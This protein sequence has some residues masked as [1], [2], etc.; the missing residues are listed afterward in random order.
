MSWQFITEFSFERLKQRSFPRSSLIMDDYKVGNRNGTT[1][2]LHFV[3]RDFKFMSY[4][5]SK[6]TEEG[7][8]V[9]KT[10]EIQ[11]NQS[12]LHN[13]EC[14]DLNFERRYSPMRD[15]FIFFCR[16]IRPRPP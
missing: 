15:R 16:L 2:S 10:F 9:D 1:M 6:Y 11:L 12:A 8:V 3:T 7:S 4:N 14:S 5:L 13:A